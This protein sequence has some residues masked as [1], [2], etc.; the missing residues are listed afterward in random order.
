MSSF[1]VLLTC[2]LPSS[3]LSGR[4][5][6][7]LPQFEWAACEW[8]NHVHRSLH[9]P[10]FAALFAARRAPMSVPQINPMQEIE[11]R[12]AST[13]MRTSDRFAA[14][15]CHYLRCHVDAR[16]ARYPGVGELLAIPAETRIAVLTACKVT[17][18]ELVSY[19]VSTPLKFAELG[20][21]A[22]DHCNGIFC[23]SLVSKFGVGAVRAAFHNTASDSI[24]LAGNAFLNISLSD[25]L[26][27]C[28]GQPVEAASVID[29]VM[30][31]WRATA[32]GR[33]AVRGVRD[34]T[35]LAAVP[36][37]LL[38]KTR[39]NLASCAHVDYNTLLLDVDR[40][41]LTQT[42]VQ[43]LGMPVFSL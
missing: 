41:E 36:V 11:L 2:K 10:F 4:V 43:M 39:V 32:P 9:V 37:S 38:V 40:S 21:D 6:T 5:H 17:V 8:V 30:V 22:L 23:Q 15:L 16:A 31:H 3:L 29:E 34:A 14:C 12:E 42:E 1:V 28:V 27:K 20:F 19:G 13:A 7:D 25:L 33:L 26:E 18:S 24:A 35:P